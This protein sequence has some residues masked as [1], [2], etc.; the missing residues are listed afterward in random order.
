MLATTLTTIVMFFRIAYRMYHPLDRSIVRT[1][2]DLGMEFESFD[3]ETVDGYLIRSWLVKSNSSRKVVI[4]CHDTGGN[5]GK[6]LPQAS[7]L[8]KTGYN[9]VLFDFRSHGESE[10]DHGFLEREDRTI[11]DL[12][13]VLRYLKARQDVDQDSIGILGFSFGAIPAVCVAA[14]DPS[15]RAVACDSG[16]SVSLDETIPRFFRQVSRLPVLPLE[17][18]FV[19][20]LKRVIGIENYPDFIRNN[21]R[22]L[23]PRPLFLV[24][25]GN[26]E[27]I[28]PSNAKTLLEWAKGPKELWLVPNCYHLASFSRHKKEYVE[29]ITNFYLQ[30]L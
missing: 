8:N 15:V 17:R 27:L 18:I 12:R 5:K 3:A 21:V 6:L 22:Q 16:P 30:Y 11:E 4:L 25:G 19:R 7:F 26:D 2:A 13:A 23:H 1:P 20:L 28:P 10:T 14:D 9:V 24:Q 29:K